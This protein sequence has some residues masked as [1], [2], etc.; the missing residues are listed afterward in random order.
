LTK[1]EVKK[2]EII[3]DSDF[4]VEEKE[5]EKKEEIKNRL[6]SLEEIAYKKI[7]SKNKI[8]KINIQ[9]AMKNCRNSNIQALSFLFKKNDQ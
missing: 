5:E 6:K 7:Y 9:K 8:T 2:R 1:W 4:S 3:L